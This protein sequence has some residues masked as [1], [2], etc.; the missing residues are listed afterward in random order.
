MV[1][2]GANPFP[3][4]ISGD[5]VRVYFNSRDAANQSHVCWA[6]VDFSNPSAPQVVGLCEQ[7]VLSP[8][9]APSFDESGVSLGSLVMLPD[10]TTYLYYLGWNLQVAKPWANYIGLAVRRPGGTTFERH[11]ENPVVGKSHADP[12]SLNYP[13][14]LRESDGWRMWYGSVQ[15]WGGPNGFEMVVRMARSAD[16]VHW[17]PEPQPTFSPEFPGEYGMARFCVLHGS[18][19]YQLWYS[20]RGDG[21][22]IYYGESSDGFNWQRAPYEPVLS[23]GS[24]A[25]ESEITCYPAVFDLKGNRYMLYNGNAYGLDGFGVAMLESEA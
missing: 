8:G 21:F 1:S 4:E 3:G 24:D 9:D 20:S 14:V 25:W 13:W 18:D 7:P 15:K 12:L 16:G 19:K 5:T 10:G 17:S 11:A 23:P 22:K 2:H 6:D